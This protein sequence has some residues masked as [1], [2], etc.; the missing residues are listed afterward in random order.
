MGRRL[1]GFLASVAATLGANAVG[2]AAPD[3]QVLQSEVWRPEA[4]DFDTFVEQR[5]GKH[6]P[7]D[8]RDPIVR[9][10]W[11]SQR[12][13]RQFDAL[14]QQTS[15]SSERI[16]Y[17]SDGLAVDGYRLAP[18]SPTGSCPVLLWARGGVGASGVVGEWDLVDLAGWAERGW[19]VV[20]SNYRGSPGSE[21]RDEFGGA[22]VADLLNAAKVARS[23][24]CA[25]KENVFV[26]GRSRGGL[27]AFRAIAEG[28][29]IRAA[30]TIGAASDL[31]SGDS[32]RPDLFPNLRAA[33]PDFE[34]E[35]A[36]RFCRRS[37]VCWPEKIG[38]PLLLMHGQKDWRVPPRYALEFGLALEKAG[39]PYELRIFWGEDHQLSGMRDAAHDTAREFFER[40]MKR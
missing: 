20:A 24:P 31:A 14:R 34:A 39:R 7:G 37:A 26:L 10:E 36:N 21:G 18:K 27:M 3:G 5:V 13:E 9:R 40:H 38:V 32:D 12:A 2:A 17:A 4:V 29:P 8:A 25:D 15:I 19:V 6:S 33:M 1:A 35:A 28:A 22:D 23:V 16:K 11:F 30:A